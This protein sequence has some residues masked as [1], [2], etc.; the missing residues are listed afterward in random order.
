[1]SSSWV[2][3]SPIDMVQGESRYFV[4]TIP[5]ASSIT[6]TPSL[7]IYNQG[8][9]TSATNL[10][11]TSGTTDGASTVTTSTVQAVKGGEEY[12]LAITATVDG[13][14]DV[15]LCKFIV[16]FPWGAA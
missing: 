9:D 6:G 10:S 15:Y 4:L 14:T 3:E 8:A 2:R 11:S 1:M 16:S 12:V 13:R 7:A 5:G